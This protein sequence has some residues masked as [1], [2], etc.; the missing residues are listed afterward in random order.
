[1]IATA[2]ARLPLVLIQA[3]PEF[4]PRSNIQG[5][6]THP[7]DAWGLASV[8]TDFAWFPKKIYA[9]TRPTHAARTICQSAFPAEMLLKRREKRVKLL[10]M[11]SA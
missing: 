6:C 5:M 7:D 8:D 4:C 1:M 3:S 10:Q 2:R 9:A 11:A